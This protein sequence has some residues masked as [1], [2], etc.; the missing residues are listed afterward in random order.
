[1][2]EFQ[3]FARWHE[4]LVSGACF[5]DQTILQFGDSWELRASLV[6][7]NPGSAIPNGELATEELT[8]RTLPYFVVPR[9]G[10]EYYKFD[11]DPL[12]RSTL[13]S[14]SEIF[15]GGVVKIYNTFNLKNQQSGE[16]L[17]SFRRHITHPRMMDEM[18]DVCFLSAPV[19]FGPGRATAKHQ[20]LGEQ[21]LRFVDRVPEGNL[22][23]IKRIEGRRFGVKA[24]SKSEALDSY[25]PSFTFKYGNTTCFRDLNG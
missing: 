17:A 6:L 8:S 23:G 13:R 12:M 15:E 19:I 18:D 16:A 20:E 25:H 14:M 11:I 2:K 9:A 1:M 21:L 22:F 7:M 4:D 3:C 10:E 5:R 24:C